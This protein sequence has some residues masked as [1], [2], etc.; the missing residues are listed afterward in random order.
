MRIC[1]LLPS[2]TEI[3]CALGLIDDLVGV[4]HECD[5]PPEVK[6]LPKLTRS[7]VHGEELSSGAIDA[8][9]SRY[10]HEHRSIYAL[11]QDLL[12][13]LNP[14]LILT[15]ELCDVCAVS[16]E[17]VQAAARELRGEHR[18]LSLEPAS[19]ETVLGTI[20]AVG[21][22]TG[23]EAR[24]E[25]LVGDLSEK[26]AKLG[27]AAA[28]LE[29]QPRVA[30]IEWLDPPFTAGHWIPE[31]VRLA[32][33]TDVLAEPGQRSRR[34]GWDEVVAARPDVLVL[35]PCGFDLQHTVREFVALALPAGWSD[36]P[37]VRGNRVYAVN[38]NAYF[39]RPGPRLVHGLE[40]FTQILHCRPDE[41][42]GSSPDWQPVQAG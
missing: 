28:A 1:S 24:A 38:A 40:I 32:G 31:M 17:Q 9:V 13:R 3:V 11:D 41:H 22:A 2:A 5:Y 8:V 14:D 26:I 39:S 10:L 35:M 18:V 21:R 37:A 4:S 29:R 30:C 16:Y 7:P 27:R 25:Q 6:A 33:G 36:L 42:A 23:T 12:E 20:G 34:L 15:Q 19:L